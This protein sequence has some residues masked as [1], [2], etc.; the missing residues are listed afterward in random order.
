[1]QDDRHDMFVRVNPKK[2]GTLAG[3]A[4]NVA[5]VTMGD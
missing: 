3:N 4:K 5:T 1:M 2:P